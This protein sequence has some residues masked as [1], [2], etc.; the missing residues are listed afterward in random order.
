MTRT[1]G[2]S[3]AIERLLDD[4]RHDLGAHPERE[5]GLVHDDRASGRPDGVADRLD[6][7]R[8][9]RSEVEDGGLDPV[10]GQGV[11]GLEASADHRAVG[12]QDAGPPSRTTLRPPDAGSLHGQVAVLLGPVAALRLRKITGSGSSIERRSNR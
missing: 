8:N 12:D 7:E 4:P 11:R 3:S 6:V 5:R 9:Q 10:L 2:A 1:T